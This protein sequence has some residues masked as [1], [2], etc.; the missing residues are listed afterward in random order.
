VQPV[1]KKCFLTFFSMKK[2]CPEAILWLSR[3]QDSTLSLPWLGVQYLVRGTRSCK[4]HGTAKKKK[5]QCAHLLDGSC[6]KICLGSAHFKSHRFCTTSFITALFPTVR[7]EEHPAA[8]NKRMDKNWCG[9]TM[10]CYSAFKERK[11]WHMI[12]HGCTMRI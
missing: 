1:I 12:Q 5:N 6:Q 4:L 7:R 3:D 8:I 9:H 11:V 10:E 2:I